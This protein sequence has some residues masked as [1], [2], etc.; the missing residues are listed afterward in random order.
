M[1]SVDQ[2]EE[3]FHGDTFQGWPPFVIQRVKLGIGSQEF[4]VM[5][6][7]GSAYEVALVSESWRDAVDAC[8]A[9]TRE[10]R[11]EAA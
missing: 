8:F 6:L 5:R 2:K 1:R 11:R 9:L 3:T 10:A 4:R 7:N